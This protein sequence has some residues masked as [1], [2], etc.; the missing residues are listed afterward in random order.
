MSKKSG[1]DERDARDVTT[2]AGLYEVLVAD[3][4]AQAL[5]DGVH[6][7]FEVVWR[8]E[9]DKQEMIASYANVPGLG[10]VLYVAASLVESPTEVRTRDILERIGEFLDGDAVMSGGHLQLRICLPMAGLT[11]ET[12]RARLRNLAGAATSIRRD[13]ADDD[14]TGTLTFG[15]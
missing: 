8:S 7:R 12:L 15:Y 3:Y 2:A 1:R 9:S 13:F 4:H 5:P 6:Y 11:V 14:E 10:D